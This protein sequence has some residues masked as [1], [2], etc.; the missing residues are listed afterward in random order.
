MIPPQRLLVATDFSAGSDLAA[1]TATRLA[2]RWKARIDWVHVGPRAS[3]TLTPSGDVLVTEYI[4]HERHQAADARD[5]LIAKAKEHGVESEFHLAEGR[6]DAEIARCAEELSSDWVVVGSHGRSGIQALL[7][8]SVAE[9]VVRAS[10]VTTLSVRS[11]PQLE[12]GGTVV[13]GE[14]LSSNHARDEAVAVAKALAARL[15]VVHSIEAAA[16]ILTNASFSPPPALVDASIKETHQRLNALS[17]AYGEGA[18]TMVTIG[19]VTAALCDAARSKNAGLIVTGAS[20]RTGLERWMLGSAAEQTL[21]HAP[22]SV[23]T[24]K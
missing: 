17:E 1:D 12:E 4:A 14:D 5:A 9:K 8:G 18:E 2:A 15:V 11:G 13:F 22:C 24:V 7:L 16:P 23:L 20:T 6:A 10:P 19:S 3:H 21:K